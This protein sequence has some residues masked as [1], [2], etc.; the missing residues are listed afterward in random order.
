MPEFKRAVN[1]IPLTRVSLESSQIFTYAVPPRLQDLVRPGQLVKIPFGRREIFG[2][3]SSIEMHRLAGEIKG[4]K[5]VLN[6]I[7]PTP[8][9]TP[10]NLILANW[11]AEYYVCSLGVVVKAMLPKFGGLPRESKLIGY[12]RSNPDYI[13][14]EAQRQ[15][16]TQI[17]NKLETPSVFLL[18]GV[19][20]S[21]K[22]EVYMQVMERLLPHG[23]QVIILVPEIS[24]TD[25]AH[26]RFARRF[27][28]EKIALL[29][30]KIADGERLWI[31]RKIR[32]REK[33]II[34]GPR[35][36]V[37]APVQDLG[38][39]VLDE[40]HDASF[41]QYD[42]NPKYHAGAVAKKLSELWQCPL[43]LG[44]ATP[45]VESY[46]HAQSGRATLLSLPHRIMAGANFPRVQIVDMRQEVQNNKS[47]VFSEYLK[48]A[49]LENLKAGR[50]IILF[51]NRRGAARFVMCR[52]CGYVASCTNCAI[53]LVWHEEKKRLLCH[54]CG[55]NYSI[56]TLCPLCQSHRI[57]HFGIGTEKLEQ[58]LRRFL[59]GEFPKSELPSISRM[60]H[61]TITKVGAYSRIYEDWV[62]GKIKI[63]I[64]TQMVSQGWDVAGVGL[65]GIISAD[66]I[67]H[68]PDFRANERTFQLLTQVAGRTGRGK[69]PGM[70][71]LQTY[72]PE[73]YAIEAAK[74]HDFLKFYKTEIQERQKFDYPPF[75]RLIKLTARDTDSGR[76]KMKAFR[77]YRQ[78]TEEH[79]GGVTILGPS[80]A[81]I[82]KLRGKYQ[83][84]TI[85]K[86]KDSQEFD[87]YKS[88]KTIS[89][90]VDIDVDPESLL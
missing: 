37:F 36:A 56:P 57:V 77:L 51:L 43:I 45:S 89:S 7:D 65:V 80:P 21:G 24:L 14:T 68:L 26:K 66:S 30:S 63:L 74:L 62:K 18:H 27:G 22:T 9:L 83:Y 59:S 4:L 15:A 79:K 2:V 60:D 40:E 23:K 76:A 35:S 3:T 19:T 33:Q 5:P 10:Q 1:V 16:V 38:L 71:I 73:N 17:I 67:L 41:K 75:T 32:E 84:Q 85:L 50:Q 64:G 44:D 58:E 49:I 6:L 78:L 34:I 82:S 48:L 12:E 55:K 13:L 88:L 72:L 39:I 47:F 86:F 28:I 8:V 54:H 52:D 11:L 42:Q 20:G 61:D 90:S 29:H 69:E 46:Y 70:V 25:P 87:W 31:W 81:F 53:S